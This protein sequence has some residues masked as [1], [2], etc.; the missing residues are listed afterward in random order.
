MATVATPAFPTRIPE[1]PSGREHQPHPQNKALSDAVRAALQSLGRGARTE[2]LRVHVRDTL[3][4]AASTHEVQEEIIRQ[5]GRLL[6]RRKKLTDA[7]KYKLM[8]WLDSNRD[9]IR[10]EKMTKSETTANAR[11]EARLSADG[12]DSLSEDM[13]TFAAGTFDIKFRRDG[14][15]G[16]KVQQ[17]FRE[18]IKVLEAWCKKV[19]DQLGVPFDPAPAGEES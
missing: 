16:G 4:V 2:S 9:R 19:G 17:K 15:G 14:G 3:G 18:R 13:V 12:A 11:K 10:N 1:V 6:T 5:R 8:Q 7:D